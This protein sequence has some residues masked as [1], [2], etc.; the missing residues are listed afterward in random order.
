MTRNEARA[1]LMQMLFQMDAQNDFSVEARD[2]YL[3]LNEVKGKQADYIKKVHEYIMN[4]M[5]AVDEK[6][7]SSSNGWKIGRMPKVDL[8]ICRLA[9]SE[10]AAAD[11]VPAPV[12]INEA[13]NL[14]KVY[15]TDAS[16]KFINGLL[17][18]A[19]K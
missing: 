15:G 7:E 11:D 17:G 18:K 5:E 3:E 16:P 13:V 14:A 2:K 9:L 6:I 19:V 4:N 10:I 1:Q 8:A 12:A